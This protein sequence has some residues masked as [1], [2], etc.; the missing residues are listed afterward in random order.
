MLYAGKTL[1]EIAGYDDA[2]MRWVLCRSRDECGK[3]RKCDPN[4]PWWVRENVD[5]D[6]KWKINPKY[7]RP[8][9]VAFDQAMKRQGKD[10]RERRIAWAEWKRDNPKYGKGGE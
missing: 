10:E 1:K 5:G 2:F 6:G 7:V 4:L 8:F 3:L 9:S